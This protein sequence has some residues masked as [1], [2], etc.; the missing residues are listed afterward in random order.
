MEE[1][2]LA[3]KLGIYNGNYLDSE[4]KIIHEN[5]KGILPAGIVT[6][7]STNEER[8]FQFALHVALAT[9]QG[10][11][12]LGEPVT[13][14]P[15]LY[16]GQH[17]TRLKAGCGA[18][19]Q[20][21]AVPHDFYYSGN[22]RLYEKEF[23]NLNEYLTERPDIAIVLINWP[24]CVRNAKWRDQAHWE[25]ERLSNYDGNVVIDYGGEQEYLDTLKKPV[26][27]ATGLYSTIDVLAYQH[28]R[29][30]F[31]LVGATDAHVDFDSDA[32]DVEPKTAIT[33]KPKKTADRFDLIVRSK[34][35]PS[36]TVPLRYN[37][38]N[39]RF[40]VDDELDEQGG[41]LRVI[42][43]LMRLLNFKLE[44]LA[45]N[46]RLPATKD[47]AQFLGLGDRQASTKLG[48]LRDRSKNLPLR[49]VGN[50][51]GPN[52]GQWDIVPA[53]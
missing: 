37:L 28:P 19:L 21:A 24:A 25:N 33:L 7:S 22:E 41:Q 5:I 51:S 20:A 31:L 14:A 9:A 2:T 35:M 3:K 16:I 36:T 12:L 26:F 29:T 38:D 40:E 46:Q 34:V 45:K 23:R 52:Y 8:E 1:Q 17:P 4:E 30:T 32:D 13:K 50:T 18:I 11:N 44:F 39:A 48:R 27:D 10:G 47:F 6:L 49:L 43:E 53:A 15:T 42:T